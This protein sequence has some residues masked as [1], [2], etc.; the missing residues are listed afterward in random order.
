MRALSHVH[1]R[2]RG[3]PTDRGG[4]RQPLLRHPEVQE[5]QRLHV[6]DILLNRLLSGARHHQRV[7]LP[8]PHVQEVR[9][10]P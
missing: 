3:Q 2:L 10:L 4:H 9:G 6:Q 8:D 5:V 7:L 1:A